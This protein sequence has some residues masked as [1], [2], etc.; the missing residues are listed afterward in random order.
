MISKVGVIGAGSMGTALAQSI[1]TRVEEVI[2]YGRRR[3][4]VDSVN[5]LRCNKNYFP[6]LHLNPNIR[7]KLT[8][9]SLDLADCEAIIITIPSSEVR[10]AVNTI[11]DELSD[12][13]LITVAKGLE[14]P[15]LKTMS[16]VIL[17]ESKNPNIVSFSGPNF[18]DEIVYGHLAGATIGTDNSSLREI[19]SDL[20]REFILDFSD[21]VRA[22]E[23]CGVLK[24]VYAIG[25]GMWDSVYSNYNEHYM[26]LNMCYKEMCTFLREISRDKDIFTKFCCF[27]DFNLTANVDKSRNRTLGLMIGKNIIKT[28]YLDSGVTFEGSK[29]VKGIVELAD[30]HNIDMPIAKFVYDVLSGNNNVRKTADFLVKYE[31]SKR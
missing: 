29:S 20:F 30:R 27:G 21:D 3:E 2:L 17:E 6:S 11:R 25:T 8:S 31:S 1:S 26:F 13:I 14:Y 12:T 4:V 23:L 18:A 22:V 9:D 19:M 15:S 16:D 24:N 5:N 28:P 10:S 7:A